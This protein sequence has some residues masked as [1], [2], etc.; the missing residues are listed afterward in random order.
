[1][2]EGRSRLFWLHA[3]LVIGGVPS[4]LHIERIIAW[5]KSESLTVLD[6]V[7]FA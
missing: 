2:S 1:M 5:M 4:T 6:S 7:G 3:S